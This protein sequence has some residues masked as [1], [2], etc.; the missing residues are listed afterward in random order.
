VTNGSLGASPRQRRDSVVDLAIGRAYSYCAIGKVC[1]IKCRGR[2]STCS[3]KGISRDAVRLA[4]TPLRLSAVIID[5]CRCDEARQC[6]FIGGRRS[7]IGQLLARRVRRYCQS[8]SST[9]YQGDEIQ[10]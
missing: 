8:Q 7:E 9:F 5:T 6:E 1:Q 4:P 10:D 3:G 2:G